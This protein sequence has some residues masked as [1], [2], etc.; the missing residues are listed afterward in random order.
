MIVY[1]VVV[2]IIMF[3]RVIESRNPDIEVGDYYRCHVG[4]RTHTI[5]DGKHKDLDWILMPSGEAIKL[6]DL[7]NLSRSLGLGTLGMPGY[8]HSLGK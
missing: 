2:S 8:V 6:Y 5:T 4:W 1:I 7:G 3:F